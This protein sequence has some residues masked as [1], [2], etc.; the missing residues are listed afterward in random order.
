ML[1]GLVAAVL[2]LGSWPTS[3]TAGAGDYANPVYLSGQPSTVPAGSYALVTSAGPGTPASPPTATLVPAGNITD[4]STS[5]VYTIVDPTGGETQPSP[6]SNSVAASSQQVT[7][8]GLPTTKTVRLYRKGNNASFNGVYHFVTQNV[9]PAGT[10]TDNDS[11]ATVS[12]HAVLPATQN[13]PVTG[14]TGVYKFVPGVPLAS[15]TTSSS[16]TSPANS[17]AFTGEGWVVNA[18]GGVSFPTENWTF[19]TDLKVSTNVGTALL[20][21]G[22]WLL[23]DTGTVVSQLIDPTCASTLPSCGESSTN[24]NRTAITSV[25]TTVNVPAFSIPSGD[26]LFVQYWRNQT[27]G[28]TGTTTIS[29]L[30]YDGTTSISYPIVNGP[31][32]PTPTAVTSPTKNNKPTLSAT[33]SDLNTADTGTIGFRVC[34]NATCTAPGDPIT[35]SSPALVGNNSSGSAQV[36]SALPDGTYYWWAQATDSASNVSGWSSPASSFVVDTTPADVPALGAPADTSRVNN[37]TLHATFTDSVSHASG[38]VEFKLCSNPSCTVVVPPG[39]TSSTVADGGAVSWTASVPDSTYYWQAR[40]IDVAGN[41]SAWSAVHSFVLDTNPPGVPTL[42]APADGSYLGAPPALH[43]TFF[44]TDTGDSGSV[45]FQVCSDPACGAG[46]VQASGSASG[47]TNGVTGSWTPTGL[48]DGVH[49]WRAQAQDTAGNQQSVSSPTAQSFT[50]DMTAPSVP[51]LGTV[52]ARAQTTPQLSAT[53]ADPPASDSGTLAFELCADSGCAS[54]LQSHTASAVANNTAAS[55][56]PN[57]LADGTYYWRARATDTAAN[58]SVWSAASSFVVDTTPPGTPTLDAPAASARV[59]SSK[60]TATFVDSDSTDSGTVDFQL[61]SDA[62]CSGVVASSTSSPAVSGGTSV[63]WTPGGLASGTTYYWRLRAT[64]FVGNQTGWTATRSFVFDTNPPGVPSLAGPA[65]GSYLGA[66]PA[67]TGTFSSNGDVGD[68]GTLEFEVCSASDSGCTSPVW[69]GSSSS[70]IVDGRGGSRTP[71]GL[72]GGTYY[73]RA[74]AQDAAGNTSTWSPVRSF[75]LDTTPPSVPPLGTVAARTRTTPQLSATFADPPASDSGTLAFE[76]CADSGCA[77]VLQNHT[78]SAVANNTAASWTP[79]SLA[80]GTYYWR[81]RATDTAA[82][83]SAWSGTSS[84][85][86]DTAAPGLPAFVSPANAARVNVAQLEGTFTDNDSTDSGTVTLQLC[87]DAAC[88]TPLTSSTSATVTGG[89]GVSWTPGSLADGTYY[90]RLSGTDVAGNQGAW[91]ATHRFVLDTNP[92]AVP[93]LAGPADGAHV[94]SRPDLGGTFTTGDNGD[95]GSLSFQVCADSGCTSVVQTGSSSSGLS[96]GTTGTWATASLA[97]GVYYWR[98]RAT[99]VAGNPSAWSSTETFTVDTVPPSAPSASGLTDGKLLDQ[100]PTL[101]S[102]YT[103]PTTGGDSGS[104]V[105][106]VCATSACT[107]LLGSTTVS[108]LHQNDA[109]SWTPPGLGDGTYYWRVRAEDS[110][111][112]LSP[113]SAARSFSIDGTPPPTPVLST[114]PG[115]RVPAAPQLGA[116]VIEPDNPGDS[117]R[118]L[119]ELCTDPACTSIITTGYTGA[120]SV[121]TP[122]GW[123][124]PVLP[125]GVYYW[126]ALAEDAAGN[127]SPWSPIGSFVVDTVAPAVPALGGPAVGA[128]VNAAR[129]TGVPGTSAT[130]VAFQVCADAACADVLAAGYAVTPASGAAPSWTPTGLSDGT[131]FWRIAAHDEAGNASGWSETKS[132]VLDQTPP[133]TPRALQATVTGMTLTLRWQTPT[134]AH[135]LSGYA[136]LVNGK[137][138][139]TLTLATHSVQIQ[140]RKS[141][142]RLF[143]VAALDAAGNVSRPTKEV[144]ADSLR[145]TN[146]TAHG[147]AAQQPHRH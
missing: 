36:P 88:S 60:L 66:A 141:E 35:F 110:A 130:G 111:G 85:V 102:S 89:T 7:V 1:A 3:A 25:T 29:L 5:Y 59:N 19:R 22:M 80:D 123:Q 146:G 32:V 105:F 40:S 69:S 128:I 121:G 116:T 108:G 15:S 95:S 16:P 101:T 143:A 144:G 119:V 97:D 61:C 114:A 18:P 50:L 33:F 115:E 4:T 99:D 140:L 75:T 51:P 14:A 73:W 92:P 82:N 122:R 137:L 53:F 117:S 31:Y 41:L 26:R 45:S 11:D 9:F 44:S 129:L 126:R 83:A 48:A 56:T 27:G 72:L 131:Y 65:D 43:A 93:S 47:L 124:A 57:S 106:E 81:A 42:G 46:T 76:L 138:T 63:S 127:Q 23:N 21:I 125:D 2:S 17:R 104:L 133:G 62:S 34:G 28:A 96:S 94:G 100:A 86:I 136:L 84:F 79:N 78:A 24:I 70:G 74:Q 91:T 118:L 38:S 103:D 6:P 109:V 55:W 20:D 10:Y 77:S 132:F 135:H 87:S 49:Y 68:N 113:W 107:T 112:N 139:R 134:V 120:G 37:A 13:K 52:A 145:L 58:A 8:S 147:A 30:A 71:S 54:V 12:A 64:D 98:A 67:L 39:G 142:T 90:W